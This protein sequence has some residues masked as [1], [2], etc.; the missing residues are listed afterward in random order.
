MDTETSDLQLVEFQ[1]NY[2]GESVY[3]VGSFDDWKLNPQLKMQ[4]ASNSKSVLKISL[5]LKPGIYKYKFYTDHSWEVDPKGILSRDELSNIIRVL[6]QNTSKDTSEYNIPTQELYKVNKSAIIKTNV[7]F[8]NSII[9][10]ISS[11]RSPFHSLKLEQFESFNAKVL[12]ATIQK[13]CSVSDF[14]GKIT[15]PPEK[16]ENRHGGAF[17]HLLLTSILEQGELEHCKDFFFFNSTESYEECKICNF[18]SEDLTFQNIVYI[19]DLVKSDELTIQESLTMK[20]NPSTTCKNC[21]EKVPFSIKFEQYPK[22]LLLG[23]DNFYKLSQLTE[24]VSIQCGNEETYIYDM[25]GC[26]LNIGNVSFSS[27]TKSNHTWY[28]NFDN[29]S[30]QLPDFQAAADIISN[31]KATLFAFEKIDVRYPKTAS[32]KLKLKSK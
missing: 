13:K 16:Y 2:G 3:L 27:V 10:V 12:A 6:P 30:K 1:W 31:S 26:S 4:P 7:M 24:K 23:S 11:F 14:A 19:L 22:F 17:V 15:I 21:K 9:S 20:L 32:L 29:Q 8:L 18:K 28:L 25:V 5:P